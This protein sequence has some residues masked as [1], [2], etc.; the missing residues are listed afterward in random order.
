M[1]IISYLN[2]I[3]HQ[4]VSKQLFYF[5]FLYIPLHT[6]QEF[7]WYRS[8]NK[9]CKSS[10]LISSTVSVAEWLEGYA[11][12]QEVRCWWFE[13]YHGKEFFVML[14]CSAFLTA[15]LAAFK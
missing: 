1:L 15:G 6:A 3:N 9:Y 13:S 2:G 12:K 11:G 8:V 10:N 4:T 5:H 14:T 7:L